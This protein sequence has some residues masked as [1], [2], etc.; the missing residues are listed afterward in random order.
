ME[1][2]TLTGDQPGCFFALEK[3]S[4]LIITLPGALPPP[5]MHSPV[6]I[7][8]NN[9]YHLMKNFSITVIQKHRTAPT[10]AG[11]GRAGVRG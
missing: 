6:A 9:L 3:P 10:A 1:I 2:L 5:L 7:V 11:G 4:M 8:P